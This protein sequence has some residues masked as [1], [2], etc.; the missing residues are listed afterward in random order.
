MQTFGLYL[1]PFSDQPLVE[2][3]KKQIAEGVLFSSGQ[4][5]ISF[6]NGMPKQAVI[7]SSLN[8]LQDVFCG[9]GSKVV[10]LFNPAC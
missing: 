10:L 5:A 1:I 8:R 6:L 2:T 7:Y 3:P 4:C 9:E